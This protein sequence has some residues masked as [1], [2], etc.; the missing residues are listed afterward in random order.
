MKNCTFT[1]SNHI[2]MRQIQ[3][4]LFCIVLFVAGTNSAFAGFVVKK[5]AI[6]FDSTTAPAFSSQT[7]VGNNEHISVFKTLKHLAKH[8]KEMRPARP[9]SSSGWEGIVAFVCGILGLLTG[10]MAIPAIIFGAIGM[11]KGRPHRG[12]AI[13]GFV[14]GVVVVALFMLL[15]IAILALGF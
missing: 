5:H 8:P 4:I 10:F 13:A 2:L 15:I 1:L 7:S 14:M 3:L 12:L 11:G 6:S 9:K